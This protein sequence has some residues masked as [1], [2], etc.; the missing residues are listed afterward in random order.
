MA[1]APGPKHVTNP[2]TIR[3][4]G[5]VIAIPPSFH[6]SSL[7]CARVPHTGSA[8]WSQGL[9]PTPLPVTFRGGVRACRKRAFEPAGPGLDGNPRSG[10]TR[11]VRWPPVRRQGA[12]S[13]RRSRPRSRRAEERPPRR[14]E[15]DFEKEVE[16]LRR[17]FASPRFEGIKRVYSAR[18]VVEQRGTIRPDYAVA[19]GA[20]EAFHARLRELFEQ[21]KCITT[22]GPYSPGPGGRDEA[23]GHRGHLPRRLGDHR[24]GLRARGSGPR[25][26][27]LPAQP[28]PD[29]A[30]PIVRALLTADKNQFHA[31]A[32]MTEEQRKATPRGRL[33]AVHHRR[34]RHRPRRRRARAQPRSAAS[35]R[36][37]CPATTSRTRSPA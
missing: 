33:P 20:A 31:R 9:L 3:I 15:M 4:R 13:A 25:P 22:F 23:D 16:E 19:R 1:R 5:E 28:V 14:R 18:E 10:W 32:R 2:T 7:T 11:T 30:A 24:Q 29:E 26:R 34:R 8:D 17:W 27:E 12:S 6:L 37:A 21:R 36:S 35:S